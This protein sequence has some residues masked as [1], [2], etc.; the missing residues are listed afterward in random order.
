M[1][2]IVGL[3][4]PGDKYAGTRHNVGFEAVDKIADNHSIS[5]SKKEHKGLVGSGYIDGMKVMLVKPQT[6]MNLSGECVR[7]I[8]DYYDVDPTSE[9]VVISDDISLEPGNIRI[10]AKGSAGGHN[11]L[12]S[13]IA[14]TGTQDFTRIKIGVG[15]R[16]AG[17]DLAEHVLS[18][19]DKNTKEAV[20]EAVSRAAEAAVMVLKDGPEAAMNKYNARVTS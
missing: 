9:I 18:G 20:T 15:E 4:N 6:Y 10:R 12:K 17:Q 16:R 11:G 2:L 3:G 5:V 1:Y 13:I 19:F 8:C 7:E 14:H